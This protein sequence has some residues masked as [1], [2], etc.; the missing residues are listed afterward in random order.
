MMIQMLEND[1]GYVQMI[2]SMAAWH[3]LFFYPS[4]VSSTY[5]AR[6]MPTT[7]AECNQV[8]LIRVSISVGV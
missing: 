7:N 8:W 1:T 2:Q 4:L 5:D 3:G 6:T